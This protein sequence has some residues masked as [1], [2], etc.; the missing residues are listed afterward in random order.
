MPEKPDS[1]DPNEIQKWRWES[2]RVKKANSEMYAQRCDIEL[3]LSVTSC[4]QIEIS[5]CYKIFID[6]YLYQFSLIIRLL[7]R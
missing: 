6:I 7:E 5:G 2:R 4:A 1:E 3:K